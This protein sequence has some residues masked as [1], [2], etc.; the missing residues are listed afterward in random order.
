[1]GIWK[2]CI[3]PFQEA[4]HLAQSRRFDVVQMFDALVEY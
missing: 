3:V 1:M 4:Q 2:Q